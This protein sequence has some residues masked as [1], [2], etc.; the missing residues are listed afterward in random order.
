[1][2]LFKKKVVAVVVPPPPLVPSLEDYDNYVRQQVGDVPKLETTWEEVKAELASLGLT[3]MLK[4]GCLPDTKIFHTN[5]AALIL[6]VPFL[7]YPADYYVAELEIDCDDYSKWASADSSRIF[8]L[9]GALQI[10]GHM[11]LGYHAF[12]GMRIAP[13]KYKLWEPNAGFE[14]AGELFDFSEHEYTPD[15]WK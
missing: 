4:D 3:L 11:P 10:W 6:M 12:S 15:K 13:V 5:E 8:K 7:T 2:C 9:S 1:M 14:C